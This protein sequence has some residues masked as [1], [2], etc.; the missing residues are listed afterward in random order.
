[1]VNRVPVTCR[2]SYALPEVI[3]DAVSKQ[4]FLEVEGNSFEEPFF[5]DEV[6]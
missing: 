3:G 4:L 6:G 5:A 1:M 2:S